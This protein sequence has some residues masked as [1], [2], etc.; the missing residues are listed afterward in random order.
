[1]SCHNYGQLAELFSFKIALITVSDNVWCVIFNALAN[2]LMCK[3]MFL[4]VCST[5]KPLG[6]R[7]PWSLI[8]AP[9][10]FGT[11]SN[12][13]LLGNWFRNQDREK[14]TKD[15]KLKKLNFIHVMTSS[16]RLFSIWELKDLHAQ[17]YTQEFK[18]NW[19]LF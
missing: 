4:K 3:T 6:W 9:D 18:I 8:A 16:L 13:G 5:L 1:M 2:G 15:W 17:T 7:I 10:C 14:R 12:Y 19:Y 11:I